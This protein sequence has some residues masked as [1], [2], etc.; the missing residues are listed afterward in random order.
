MPST[1]LRY[2]NETPRDARRRERHKTRRS[3]KQNARTMLSEAQ[4][5][6]GFADGVMSRYRSGSVRL[7]EIVSRADEKCRLAL[8][9][10]QGEVDGVLRPALRD[11]HDRRRSFHR[12]CA[13]RGIE[14]VTELRQDR[15]RQTLIILVLLAIEWVGAG[16]LYGAHLAYPILGLAWAVMPVFFTFATAYGAALSA[17]RMD[18]S[19]SRQMIE[20]SIG[21]AVFGGFGLLGLLISAHLRDR[22]EAAQVDALESSLIDGVMAGP[23][24]LSNAGW[25]LLL[26]SLAAFLFLMHHLH[27]GREKVPGLVAHTEALSAA[28]NAVD[29]EFRRIDQLMGDSINGTVEREAEKVERYR[30]DS[31]EAVEVVRGDLQRHGIV[32]PANPGEIDRDNEAINLLLE[33]WREL[34]RLQDAI[35]AIGDLRVTL[36]HAPAPDGTQ[37]TAPV[38][39]EH[40]TECRRLDEARLWLESQLA[41]WHFTQTGNETEDSNHA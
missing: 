40:F 20:S 36:H 9:V 8:E 27:E 21:M 5:S 34:R 18:R 4:A 29:R 38:R 16:V 2:G 22:F 41:E 1:T 33:K 26:G 25:L 19:N 35:F 14:P 11:W 39:R 10:V 13:E 17:R 30:R 3:R 37:S 6:A 12:F 28:T 15:V 7:D 24:D 32:D 31:S 23:L